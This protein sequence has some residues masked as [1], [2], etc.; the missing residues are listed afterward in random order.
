M[1]FA[2]KISAPQQYGICISIGDKKE[3]KKRTKNK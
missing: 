1:E 3:V 2:E